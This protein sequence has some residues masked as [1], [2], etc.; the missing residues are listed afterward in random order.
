MCFKCKTCGTKLRIRGS[1]DVTENTRSVY[2]ECTN[3]DCREEYNGTHS[4]GGIV[5]PSK[6]KF[7]Q[8]SLDFFLNSVPE[9]KRQA[10]L[11]II[12]E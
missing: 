1:N 5:R 8:I 6:T 3:S 2:Y 12:N 11:K 9:H 10:V 7:S 4:L